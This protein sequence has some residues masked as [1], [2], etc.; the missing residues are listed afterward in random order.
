MRR[1]LI[2]ICLVLLL[3]PIGWSQAGNVVNF[4]SFGFAVDED[5]NTSDI[6]Y[7]GI[8]AFVSPT[9]YVMLELNGLREIDSKSN[10][11]GFG[12]TYGYVLSNYFILTGSVSGVRFN[13]K[14]D[15]TLTNRSTVAGSVTL[16]PWGNLLKADAGE[17]IGLTAGIE[18][19][20]GTRRMTFGFMG[21]VLIGK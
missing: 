8:G 1:S 5:G 10:D 11:F 3:C 15:T 9:M 13:D 16:F 4:T 17:R 6:G 19:M 12:A 21:T 14:S 7:T 2:A 20:P 18:Y